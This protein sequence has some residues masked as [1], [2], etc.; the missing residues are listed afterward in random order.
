MDQKGALSRAD[1]LAKSSASALRR[2]N[3]R[4]ES[5]QQDLLPVHELTKTLNTA[6]RN[7]GLAMSD[8]SEACSQLQAVV[9]LERMLEDEQMQRDWERFFP[10]P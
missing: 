2:L 10:V 6:H 8:L 4:V 7:I 9:A 5:L 1:F 3:R